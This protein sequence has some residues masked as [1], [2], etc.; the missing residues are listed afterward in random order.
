MIHGIGVDI[1]EI[2]RFRKIVN[3]H[4]DKF[5]KKILAVNEYDT[6][7]K[8]NNKE[9]YLSKCWA[10]KEAFVKAM[11]TGFT[12]VYKKTDIMYNSPGDSR[13][14]ID[15]SDEIASDVSMR[16]ITINLSVSDETS[17]VVAFV[18]LEYQ[19]GNFI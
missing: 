7:L 14:T 16:N 5:A 15:V 2:D 3:R 6:Y 12:G 11:G 10:V 13:P 1:V 17:N 19:D 18:V 9:T 4:G 8:S